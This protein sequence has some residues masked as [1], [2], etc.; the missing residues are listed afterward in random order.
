MAEDDN[1]LNDEMLEPSESTDSDELGER[2]G[3]EIAEPPEHWAGADRVGTTAAEEREGETLDQRLA[4][5]RP[6]I[7]PVEQPTR[8]SANTAPEDLDETVDDVTVPGEPVDGEDLSY[9]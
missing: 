2:V 9:D 1:D 6:D 8:P 4:E 3:D 5:E 7:Q